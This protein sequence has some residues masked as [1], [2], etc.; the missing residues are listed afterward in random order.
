M[1]LGAGSQWVIKKGLSKKPTTEELYIYI[2]RCYIYCR[3]DNK[4]LLFDILSQ[5][6]TK[7]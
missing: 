6:H 5:P 4:L 1:Y 7:L 3:K 2:K